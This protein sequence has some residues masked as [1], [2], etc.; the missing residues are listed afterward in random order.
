MLG[1]IIGILVGIY[2]FQAVSYTLIW[3]ISTMT[4]KADHEDIISIRSQKRL[5]DYFNHKI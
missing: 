3:I 4:Y 1:L 5:N 2:I